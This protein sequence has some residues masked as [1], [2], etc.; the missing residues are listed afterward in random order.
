ME[1]NRGNDIAENGRKKKNRIMATKLPKMEG[2]KKML[3]SQHFL[4]QITDG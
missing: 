3:L 4:Q 1:T 2:K